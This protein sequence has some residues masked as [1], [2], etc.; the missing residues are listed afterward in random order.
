MLLICFTSKRSPESHSRR[1]AL[2]R[3]Q[4]RPGSSVRGELYRA[5][6]L[7]VASHVKSFWNKHSVFS[8]YPSAQSARRTKTQSA[9]CAQFYRRVRPV[10]MNPVVK[11]AAGPRRG[12][13]ST[14]RWI[15]CDPKQLNIKSHKFQLRAD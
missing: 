3:T 13:K 1:H 8:A 9:V 12:K 5:P 11:M 15:I 6:T 14:H 2:Q 10:N 4:L 7:L